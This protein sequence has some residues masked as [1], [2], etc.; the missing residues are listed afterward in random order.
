M[1]GRGKTDVRPCRGVRGAARGGGAAAAHP[2]MMPFEAP[3]ARDGG[4]AAQPS[5][6]SRCHG[7]KIRGPSAVMAMVN[8]KWA[9]SE[10]SWE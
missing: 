4:A 9:A 2:S 3:P 5:P 7:V 1:C 8:S 10:P 6:F